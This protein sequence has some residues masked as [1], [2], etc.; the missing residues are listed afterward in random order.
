MQDIKDTQDEVTQKH[1][2]SFERKMQN[3]WLNTVF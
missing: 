3:H 2:S 1:F